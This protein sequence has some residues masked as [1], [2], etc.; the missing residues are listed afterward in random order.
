MKNSYYPATYLF[1]LDIQ[2]EF[3]CI[4]NLGLILQA[5]HHKDLISCVLHFLFWWFD[6][7]KRSYVGK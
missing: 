6:M 2:V 7:L 3:L 1:W 4:K 5:K